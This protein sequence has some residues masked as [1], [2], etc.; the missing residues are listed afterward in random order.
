MPQFVGLTFGV[1]N[2]QKFVPVLIT[3]HMVGHKF[4]E[5][6]PTRTYFGHAADKKPVVNFGAYRLGKT[7]AGRRVGE[8]D[9]LSVLKNLRV[10]PQKLNLVAS[11]IKEWTQKSLAALTFSKRR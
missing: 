4:G 2:G 5:F 3:E 9:A 6:A 10:S 8:A 1:H 7:S 11:M